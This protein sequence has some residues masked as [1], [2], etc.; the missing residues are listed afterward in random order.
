ML[1]AMHKGCRRFVK[2]H[3][4]DVEKILQR[5]EEVHLTLSGTKSRFGVLEILVVGHM[6]GSFGRKPNP[7]KVI[8]IARLADCSSITKSPPMLR[9]LDYTCGRPIVV[10]V[11][12]SPRAICWVVGQEDEEGVRFASRFGAKILSKRQRDYPQVK[13]ELWEVKTAMLTD[14]DLLIGAHVVLETDCLPLLGMIANC[15]TPDIHMLRWIA[16]IR[17]LNPELRHIAGK[18]NVVADIFSRARYNNEEEMLVVAEHEEEDDVW[19]RVGQQEVESDLDDLFNEE[20]YGG[21]FGD[22]GYYLS[23]LRRRE[24]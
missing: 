4:L 8:A 17:S 7:E 9:R 16:Y 21:L 3:V 10:T 14:R 20:L 22:I 13:C 23:T 1:N 18:R 15:T 5:L 19:C 11:D 2:H 12:T 6:C 24:T